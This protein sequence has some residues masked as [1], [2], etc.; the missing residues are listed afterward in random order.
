MDCNHYQP[1]NRLKALDNLKLDSKRIWILC[2]SQARKEKRI[3]WI[4]NSAKKIIESNP[5]EKIGFIYV[6]DGPEKNNLEKLVADLNL[7]KYFLLVGKQNSLIDYYQASSI[8]VHAASRESFGLVIAEA[9]ACGLPV[10]ATAAAGPTEIILDG[11]TG[12]LVDIDDQIM[13]ES[14]IQS[15]VKDESLRVS[16]GKSGRMRAV[17]HFSIDRQARE[18]ADATRKFINNF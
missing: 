3:D 12:K 8:M 18:I 1:G 10:V 5:A 6:G 14:A 4:I 9:M 16:H 15:Y 11:I 17:T 7:D 13:F 2:V